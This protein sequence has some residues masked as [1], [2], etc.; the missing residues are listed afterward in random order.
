MLFFLKRSK[1]EYVVLSIH[2]AVVQKG[3]KNTQKGLFKVN[4]YFPVHLISCQL[5]H[6]FFMKS[7]K[8]FALLHFKMEVSAATLFYYFIKALKGIKVKRYVW[9]GGLVAP[10]Y[11]NFFKQLYKRF[12]GLV[13]RCQTHPCT[14]FYLDVQYTLLGSGSEWQ[15]TRPGS[16]FSS[17]LIGRS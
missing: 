4:C 11:N 10:L 13:G 16:N 14:I 1:Q 8:S 7:R 3:E 12:I 9:P 2:Q 15:K 6:Q 17:Y 5:S